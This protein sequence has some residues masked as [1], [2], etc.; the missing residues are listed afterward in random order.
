MKGAILGR[1]A[2]VFDRKGTIAQEKSK[3][4]N[5]VPQ[6]IDYRRFSKADWEL[7]DK[8]ERLV[9]EIRPELKRPKVTVSGN[10]VASVKS[11]DVLNNHFKTKAFKG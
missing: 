5:V 3:I 4:I 8:A 2:S 10:G 7:L 11:K 9:D 6:N 1:A